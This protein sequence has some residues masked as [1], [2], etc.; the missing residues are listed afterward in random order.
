MFICIVYINKTCET[1]LWFCSTSFEIQSS[2]LRKVLYKRDEKE[3]HPEEQQKRV[4]LLE[5]RWQNWGL[6]KAENGRKMALVIC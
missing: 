1:A 4:I 6:L 2:V 3:E 5:R